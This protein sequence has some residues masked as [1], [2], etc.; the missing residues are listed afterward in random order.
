MIFK[1]QQKVLLAVFMAGGLFSFYT[2]KA[3]ALDVNRT[4]LQSANESADTIVFQNYEGPHARIDSAQTITNIGTQLAISITDNT[5]NAINTGSKNRYYVIHAVDTSVKEKLDADILILGENVGVDHITNVRRIISGFLMQAYKYNPEDASTIATFITVYNAVYRG[6]L[7]TFNAKYKEIV[8]QNLTSSVGM[9]T[10]YKMWPGNTQIVIPLSEPVD[11]GLSTIDTSVISDKDVVDSMRE[12]DDRGIDERSNMMDIKNRESEIASEQAKDA[13]K[14]AVIEQAKADELKQE[15]AEAQKIANENP[16]DLQAQEIAEQKKLDA[17]EQQ[18]KADLAAATATEKQNKADKKQNEAKNENK[19][20]AKDIK[21]LKEKTQGYSEADVSYGLQLANDKKFLSK[22]IGIDTKN[23]K[24]VKTSRLE[25]I[26]NRI[27]YDIG[28]SLIAIA[29]ENGGKNSAVKL[30][31]IDKETLQIAKESEQAVAEDSVLI[32]QG[33][34]YYCVI[35]DGKNYY[36]ASYDQNL[37]LKAKSTVGVKA[38]TPIV[39][40]S[41]SIMVNNE[42]GAVIRLSPSDLS[43]IP[44]Q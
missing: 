12:T 6:K 21:E 11:G 5:E 19:E 25:A 18:K 28:T 16:D 30:V 41:K 34:V 24:I 38:N 23:N 7:D 40:D 10:N 33:S 17:T 1:K 39:I 22:I 20:I 9:D 44:L 29:G 3:A 42:K 8:T 13:Q 32:Q 43:E 15:A 36:I 27:I 37:V 35:Q 31:S 26:R 2:S 4:E 14:E